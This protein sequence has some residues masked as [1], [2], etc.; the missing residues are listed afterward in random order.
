MGTF[1]TT[2][3]WPP[4]PNDTESSRMSMRIPGPTGATGYPALEL[5]PG[6]AVVTPAVELAALVP[7]VEVAFE[8]VGDID[9]L[10]EAGGFQGFGGRGRALAAAADQD[11]RPVGGVA[12]QHADLAHEVRIQV[13]FGAILPGDVVRAHR[14]ADEIEFGVAA[15]VDE[16]GLGVLCEEAAGLARKH[17]LHLG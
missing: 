14:V 3:P 10:A 13:P 12:R 11:D 2:R 6:Q 5:L 1:V 15:A 9:G 8:A 7:F 17:F 4:A 16:Q